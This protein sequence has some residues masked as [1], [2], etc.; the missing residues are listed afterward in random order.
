MSNLKIKYVDS[1]ANDRERKEK[2]QA[3]VHTLNTIVGSTPNKIKR[4]QEIGQFKA[5]K[6]E[7]KTGKRVK[8]SESGVKKTVKAIP[9][10]LVIAIFGGGFATYLIV[11]F[12][13]KRKKQKRLEQIKKEQEEMR[14]KQ[15]QEKK[16]NID[17]M[18]PFREDSDGRWFE[19]RG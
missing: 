15:E 8:G 4:A 18:K 16:Q 3:Q 10:F 7:S 19:R 6:F 14:R 2:K 9:W 13:K 12:L 5:K 1:N 17:P 11:R